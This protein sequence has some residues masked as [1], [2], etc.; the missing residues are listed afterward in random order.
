MIKII[1]FISFILDLYL[2]LYSQ[3][4]FNFIPLFTIVS[5]LIIYP[6]Y[7]KNNNYYY[8]I[9]LITGL[10]Y[11][12]LF[13]NTLILNMLLFLFM[14]LII[15]A[16]YNNKENNILYG[17]LFNSFILLSYHLSIIIILI[18]INYLSFSFLSIMS[19]LLS[20]LIINN[21]YYIFIYLL[22]NKILIKKKTFYYH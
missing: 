1:I 13:T 15:S 9:C 19:E 12:L 7:Y 17:L 4:I 2:S 14:G 22:I 20:V 3:L 16:L 8:K 21:L 18:L 5:L 11:D 10:L 6:F